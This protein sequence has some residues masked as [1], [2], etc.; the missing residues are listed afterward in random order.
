MILKT[1][2]NL[3]SE[4]AGNGTSENFVHFNPPIQLDI[5]KEY[6]VGLDNAYLW[7]SWHNIS[8]TLGNNLFKYFNG[9]AWVVV[10]IPNGSYNIEDL[11]T[12]L[13]ILIDKAE[14]YDGSADEKPSDT[15]Y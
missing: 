10:T 14:E 1:T 13:K 11:N 2:V 3:N 12:T 4:K 15:F 6:E 8:K 9:N 5:N 7:Y